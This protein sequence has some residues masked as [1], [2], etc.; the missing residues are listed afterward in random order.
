MWYYIFWFKSSRGTNEMTVRAYCERPRQAQ[1]KENCKAWCSIFGAWSSS[2]NFV[3]YGWRSLPRRSLPKNRR[4]AIKRFR[5]VYE[6][7]ERANQRQHV[8]AMLL[9]VPP[10]NGEKCKK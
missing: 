8:A 2:E 3:N 6:A 9:R 7:Y 4:E 1:L 5:A 10:F